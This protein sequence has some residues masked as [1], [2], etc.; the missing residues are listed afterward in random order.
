MAESIIEMAQQLRHENQHQAAPVVDEPEWTVFEVPSV[1]RARCPVSFQNKGLELGLHHR[2]LKKSEIEVFK[3]DIARILHSKLAA[4]NSSWDEF[5]IAVVGDVNIARRAYSG[6]SAK[7]SDEEVQHLLALDALF[8]VVL[9]KYVNGRGLFLKEFEALA[10]RVG[11]ILTT[12]DRSDFFLIENQVPMYLLQS[13]IRELCE[14]DEETQA[15]KVDP[16]FQ[17]ESMVE[18][19]LEMVLNVAVLQLYPFTFPGSNTG[20]VSTNP[21]LSSFFSP[22]FSLN[23]RD[24]LHRHLLRTYPVEPLEKSLINCQHL[25]DCLY[26]VICGHTLPFKVKQDVESNL[27]LENIP[28]ATRLEA[29]GISILGTVPTLRDIRLSGAGYF[30]TAKLRL[31]KV[32]LYD[33]SESV[34]HN[35]ALHEHLT[36]KGRCGDFVCYLQ[37]MTSLCI[38]VSDLQVLCEQGVINNYTGKETILE[39]WDQTRIGVSTPVLLPSYWVNCNH[40]V[41]QHRNARLKRW[42]QECWTLFFAKPW[43]LVSVL[44]A[45]VLLF[46]TATQTYLTAF[47]R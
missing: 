12:I 25:L 23:S 9:F 30:R 6:G 4:K 13:V 2:T 7:F 40:R 3:I 31:P 17:I 26:T 8:L 22:Q 42:R 43:T 20:I 18:D 37:C 47:P 1:L 39:V 27:A 19:E 41:H 38:N 33:Y 44:A 5:A 15:K 28:S 34:F 36:F 32:T 21:C 45:V 11:E 35:L 46:L 24:S 16:D 10:G 29:V 14:L